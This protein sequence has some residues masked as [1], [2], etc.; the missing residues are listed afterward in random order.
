MRF[1]R[2]PSRL[3]EAR[4]RLHGM[5]GGRLHV[6][7]GIAGYVRVRQDRRQPRAIDVLAAAEPD[8]P[9]EIERHQNRLVHI[10][11]PAVIAGEIIHIGGIADDQRLQLRSRHARLGAGE[12]C[13]EF[14]FVEGSIVPA[15]F[16]GTP[17]Q[18]IVISGC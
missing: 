12:P 1:G 13:C 18:S 6:I 3:D 11:G 9:V 17:F 16:H 15:E 14:C 7:V 2:W 10:K 5:F 4:Q 8:R